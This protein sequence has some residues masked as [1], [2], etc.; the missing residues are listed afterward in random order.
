MVRANMRRTSCS[1]ESTY[2]EKFSQLAT[3]TSVLVCMALVC[4]PLVCLGLGSKDDKP[5]IILKGSCVE[6][7]RVVEADMRKLPCDPKQHIFSINERKSYY[8]IA[9]VLDDGEDG[10]NSKGGLI[11]KVDKHTGRILSFKIFK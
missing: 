3:T 2:Q 7:L 9:V 10:L 8:E 4:G 5:T 1:P 6:A 11:Y